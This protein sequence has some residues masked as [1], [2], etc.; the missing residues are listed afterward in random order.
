MAS[1]VFVNFD[2]IATVI[3]LLAQPVELHLKIRSSMARRP[4][5]VPTISMASTWVSAWTW[6]GGRG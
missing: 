5:E 6:C 3:E 1:S 2:L 4:T